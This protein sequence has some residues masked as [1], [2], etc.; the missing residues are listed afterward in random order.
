MPEPFVI[1]RDLVGEVAA[2]G[3]GAVGFAPGQPVWCNSLGHAGR[4]GSFAEYAV[5]AADR[6]YPA[7]PEI[8]SDDLVAAAHP[9]AS[10]WLG[11]FRHGQLRPGQSVYI[12]GGAGNVGSAAVALAA[13]AGARVVTTAR[14]DDFAHVQAL[15]AT[16]VI[17]YNAPD[18]TDR[19]HRA[20]PDGFAVYLDTSGHSELADGV[21][22]LAHGGRLVAM[23]GLASTPVL[24]VGRLYTRDASIVGFAISNA[25]TTDLSKAADG[26]LHLLSATGWRPR[27]AELLPLSQAADAHRRL[28]Q[29]QLTGRLV[30]HP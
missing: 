17:D 6:L 29:G 1:G 4:Q 25:S 10:A 27:I 22:L 14:P 16:E 30:L 20:V 23:V 5:V 24:P 2:V 9:A 18:L 12:G 11:L 21:D 7:P 3:P 28:E 15:G 8:D 19:L 13:A 26:V